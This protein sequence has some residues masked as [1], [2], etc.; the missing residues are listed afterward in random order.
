MMDA[1]KQAE[2]NL[3]KQIISRFGAIEQAV[4]IGRSVCTFDRWKE[5]GFFIKKGQKSFCVVIDNKPYF[6]FWWTQV[7]DFNRYI[8]WKKRQE[9]KKKKS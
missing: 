8:N 9:K 7:Y 4:D 5:K 2:K 6:F 3:K 1:R